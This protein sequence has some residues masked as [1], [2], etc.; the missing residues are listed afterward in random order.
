MEA[1]YPQKERFELVLLLN[2]LLASP[3]FKTWL[4][5]EALDIA[6]MLFTPEGRPR[7]SIFSIAHLSDSERMFFVSLLLNEVLGW[8]RAQPGTGSLRAIVY[9]DEIFGYFP[10]VAEPPSKRPLLTLL[11]QARAFGLGILLATQNPVDLDYKGLANAGTWFIG[12]LQTERDKDRLLEGLEGVAAGS[13]AKFDRQEMEETLAGLGKRVFLMYNA[14][15]DAPVVFQTRWTMSYLSG[16]LTRAQ[17]K[18]L[19]DPR[20]PTVTAAT[21]AVP[22]TAPT[23]PIAAPTPPHTAPDTTTAAKAPT[24]LRPTTVPAEI[25]QF[26]LP[27]RRSTNS[28]VIYRPGVL[29]AAA[30]SFVSSSTGTGTSL[31][32][33]RVAPTP[34][35]ALGLDWEQALPLELTLEEL[36]RE[37]YPE[38]AFAPLPPAMEKLSSYRSWGS[39]FIS[40]AFRTQ[41]VE[42][43]KSPGFKRTSEPGESEGEF[44]ARLQLLAHEKRDALTEKLRAKYNAKIVTLEQQVMR[45]EHAVQRETE[46]ARE[47][48]MQTA[49]S[50]GATLFGAFMGRKRISAG[51]LGRATTAARHV[52]RSMDKAGD[53]RRAQETLADKQRRL[54]DLEAQFQREINN[55]SLEFDP[56][57]EVLER[58][59][60]K[61]RK[62]DIIVDL[63]GVAWMPYRQDSGG[64]MTNAWE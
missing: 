18:T 11:K 40:W 23:A 47:R 58:V 55:L 29:V 41:A 46:Q 24:I 53:I 34:E 20:R 45:A 27:L 25:P 15:E 57:T 49:I 54:A 51:T 4:E 1:F 33:R 38:I 6:R 44:R 8:M 12:R 5:G 3:T 2:N 13:D 62:S 39:D 30:V 60:V 59:S 26:F 31:R 56:M 10:P 7:V 43:L 21:A 48:K 17:I 50:L 63:I 42:V 16:P 35:G 9:M 64:V 19:M 22:S 61:P 52:S 36:D 32:V 14:H 28:D 37:S